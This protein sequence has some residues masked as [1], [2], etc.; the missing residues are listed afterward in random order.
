[1]PG[2]FRRCI[3]GR[4]YSLSEGT[5]AGESGLVPGQNGGADKLGRGSV[6]QISPAG[7][8]CQARMASRASA[9]APLAVLVDPDGCGAHQASVSQETFEIIH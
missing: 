9:L 3:L 7:L 2:D 8:E 1:M 5:E 6:R 4:R